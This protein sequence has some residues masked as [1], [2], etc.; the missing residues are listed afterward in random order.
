MLPVFRHMRFGDRK[1][2]YFSFWIAARKPWD[3]AGN[4]FIPSRLR[5]FTRSSQWPTGLEVGSDIFQ[6]GLVSRPVLISD[7]PC[8]LARGCVRIYLNLVAANWPVGH[9]RS[10]IPYYTDDYEMATR[11]L[12]LPVKPPHPT[13]KTKNFRGNHFQ[14]PTITDE[15]P[16]IIARKTLSNK[17]KMYC[18]IE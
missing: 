2:W 9:T 15:T 3:A 8:T 17:K 13:I 10:G 5:S 7:S 16:R 11:W 12:T 18:I 1:C 4:Y 14:N 6:P